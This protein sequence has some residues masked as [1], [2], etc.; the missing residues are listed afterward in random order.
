MKHLEKRVQMILRCD[1]KFYDCALEYLILYEVSF[2]KISA[3][4]WIDLYSVPEW[5]EI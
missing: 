2:D 5:K 3:F 4:N 1:L